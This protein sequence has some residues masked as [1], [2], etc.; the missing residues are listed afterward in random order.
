MNQGS[1]IFLVVAVGELRKI[2]LRTD[3][4]FIFSRI[5]ANFSVIFGMSS[6]EFLLT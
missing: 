5:C 4:I 1:L 6:Y 3:N 2:N